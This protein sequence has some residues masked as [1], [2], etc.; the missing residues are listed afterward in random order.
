M[1]KIYRNLNGTGGHKWSYKKSGD[2]VIRTACLYAESVTIKQPSGQAFSACLAGGHRAIFAWFKSPAVELTPP[3]MP[4]T[5]QRVRFNPRNG[6]TFFH[7]D[8][9]RVDSLS[10]VWFDAAGNCFGV[11]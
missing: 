8:G 4:E 10:Q 6:D 7:I 9:E 1:F 5:A 3:P 11:L 2:I